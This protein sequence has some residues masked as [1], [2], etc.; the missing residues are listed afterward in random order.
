MTGVQTCA[1]PISADAR[2][3]DLSELDL[4]L[5]MAAGFEM[6]NAP[7]YKAS[8][9]PLSQSTRGEIAPRAELPA[10]WQD[11]LRR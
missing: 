9:A 4:G 7:L 8:L 1:L 10:H 2:W 11:L 5:V 6:A 3:P